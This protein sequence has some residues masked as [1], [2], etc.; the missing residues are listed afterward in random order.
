MP[1]TDAPSSKIPANHPLSALLSI[2]DEAISETLPSIQVSAS[3]A[4]HTPASLAF[5]LKAS[6]LQALYSINDPNQFIE[7]LRFN[8]L[9][10][11][12]MGSFSKADQVSHASDYVQLQAKLLDNHSLSHFLDYVIRRAAQD[13]SPNAAYIA[14]NLSRWMNKHCPKAVFFKEYRNSPVTKMSCSVL[15]PPDRH[16]N[17]PE[18]VFYEYAKIDFP[19]RKQRRERAGEEAVSRRGARKD[20]PVFLSANRQYYVT[21]SNAS[22]V[23]L[24]KLAPY[25]NWESFRDKLEIVLQHC[26]STNSLATPIGIVCQFSNFMRLRSD[27]DLSDYFHIVLSS[28]PPIQIPLIM[29]ESGRNYEFPRQLM[30]TRITTKLRYENDPAS[31]L[32]YSFEAEPKK[33]SIEVGLDL[34][35][36]WT[37]PVSMDDVL[38]VTNKLKENAYI[39]FH[40]LITDK[41]RRLFE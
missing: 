2:A 3:V 19:E 36:V 16:P 18:A 40:S 4:D 22:A 27:I 11:W 5:V 9:F 41:A 17:F 24:T 34:E 1:T 23:I 35:T 21:L 20:E 7:Q 14:S 13:Q 32:I 39:A 31:F 28:P 10:R 38:T 8:V 29:Q 33:D 15:F 37:N 12:F 26:R 25:E 30:S 6:L